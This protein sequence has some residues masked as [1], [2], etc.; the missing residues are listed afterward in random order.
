MAK[1]VSAYIKLQV[2]AGKANPA[3]PI[4]P[5]LGQHGV[6][7]PGFCKEFNERTKNDVGLIIPVVITEYS[8]RTFTFITKTPPVPVLIKKKL[9]LDSASARPNRDKVGKLTQEQLREIATIK[10][11][12]LNAASIEAA[13]SM[14][15]GTARSM[16]VTVE[17]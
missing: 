12:D 9:N 4:G 6:N 5:A 8:D 2:A 16:G 11:P 1:K 17:E 3:P 10:M 13:M 7:I 14:V 15:A